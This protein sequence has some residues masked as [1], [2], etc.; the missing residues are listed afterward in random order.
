M[1][2]RRRTVTRR[3]ARRLGPDRRQGDRRDARGRPQEILLIPERDFNDLSALIHREIGINLTPSK[4]VL[5]TGRLYPLLDLWDLADYRALIT[6]LEKDRQG[7]LWID[8]ANRITTGHTSFF[9]EWPHFEFLLRT[10]LPTLAAEKKGAGDFDLRVWSAACSTGE[11]PY[12]LAMCLLRHFGAEYPRWKAGV[13]ATDLSRASLATARAGRYQAKYVKNVPR[14]WGE[15]FARVDAERVEVVEAVRREVTFRCLNL[16]V[17][18]ETFP[19]RTGF[20][21]IFC[22]NVMI[23]FDEPTRLALVDRLCRSLRPGGYLFIGHSGT[24]DR[25]EGLVY[26]SSAVYRRAKEGVGE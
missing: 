1:T 2:D 21:V 16:T 3:Q 15:F 17:P 8:L 11:E 4:R 14:G 24:L 13:L 10:A 22:R 6:R 18:R 5:V 9:R 25:T 12:T 23:Y 7:R 19:F 20:D 26:Q